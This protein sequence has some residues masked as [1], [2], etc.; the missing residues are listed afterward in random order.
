MDGEYSNITIAT[1]STATTKAVHEGAFSLPVPAARLQAI[2]VAVPECFL[3]IRA[4]ESG[5]GLLATN[6]AGTR[7]APAVG[8]ITSLATIFAGALLEA[9]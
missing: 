2:P 8:Q 6:D 5:C 3:A 1:Y 7:M 9:I 4:T